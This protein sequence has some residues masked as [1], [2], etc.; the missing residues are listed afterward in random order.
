MKEAIMSHCKGMKHDHIAALSSLICPVSSAKAWRSQDLNQ[1][2]R[3][4]S[5]G[6]SIPTHNILFSG[7]ILGISFKGKS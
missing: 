4:P 1:V 6:F 3:W 5:E 2:V 7:R